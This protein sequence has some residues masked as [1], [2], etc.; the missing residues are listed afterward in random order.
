[1]STIFFLFTIYLPT[2]IMVLFELG[3][4]VIPTPSMNFI[5][6]HTCMASFA[7]VNT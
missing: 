6:A 1:M 2:I 5:S 4:L 3:Y 7:I